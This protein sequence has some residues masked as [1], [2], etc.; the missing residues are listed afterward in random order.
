MNNNI[1]IYS[2]VPQYMNNSSCKAPMDHNQHFSRS[3]KADLIDMNNNNVYRQ[4]IGKP[5]PM[6]AD[7]ISM[8]KLVDGELSQDALIQLSRDDNAIPVEPLKPIGY[9]YPKPMRMLNM[10]ILDKDCC[11]FREFD[12]KRMMNNQNLDNLI[13]T[14]YFNFLE[15]SQYPI[16]KHT[17]EEI[18]RLLTSPNLIMFTIFSKN[19]MVAYLVSEIMKLDDGRTVLYISYL[20]VSSKYRNTGLGHSLLNMGI[21]R[22]SLL[23]MNAVVLIA[24]TEDQLVFEFYM[25]RGFMYDPFLRRYDR[26]DVLS[27]SL[28]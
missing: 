5:L 24:D 22:A 12:S 4:Y 10:K 26:Y 20:Y 1:G 2:Q 18:R 21:Q 6:D 27:F 11:H 15:L 14:I 13:E 16:L 28:K 3:R 25:K 19:N 23:H 9:E 7:T 8:Y 17:P